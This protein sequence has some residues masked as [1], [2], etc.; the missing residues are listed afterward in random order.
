VSI[1]IKT[2]ITSLFNFHVLNR[3]PQAK[4]CEKVVIPQEEHPDINFVG[5]LIGPR[6]NTLKSME[7]DSGS[8]IIIRGKGSVKEGKIGRKD[9]QPMPGED[10]PLHAF[11]TGPSID[12]VKKAV[13]R[14]R[15]IIR[16]GIE[17]P[18]NQNDLRRN[19]LRELALLNGTL[20]ENDGPKCNNCGSSTHRSWQCPD[21]PNVTNNVTCN[22]CGGVGHIS[23]DC[24]ERRGAGSAL[25]GANT[26]KIDEEYLSL[27]AELGEGP[28]PSSFNKSTASSSST[29]TYQVL[30]PRNLDA[31]KAL[32]APSSSSSGSG[33]SGTSSSS[34]VSNVASLSAAGDPYSGYTWSG[35]P[36]ASTT[37]SAA[38][39]PMYNQAS[40]WY[41]H[42]QTEGWNH[43]ASGA[44]SWYGT[45]PPPPPPPPPS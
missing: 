15:D 35:Y 21:K 34:S 3:A 30:A 10:E 40:S 6:G 26:Q 27:M 24:K 4:I 2:S 37:D 29:G 9:G 20:R 19:Q 41:Q 18:E 7:K 44:G 14:I 33:L 22:N 28:P 39:Y 8:K 25:T 13:G 5:L 36:N 31:P 17:V 32:A 45:V 42:Q 16:Q 11:V 12:A 1:L 23:R 38:G 43:Q